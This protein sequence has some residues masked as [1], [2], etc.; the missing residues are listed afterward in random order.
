[1]NLIIAREKI[2]AIEQSLR[3]Y[4][5]THPTKLRI[6]DHMMLIADAMNQYRDKVIPD[7]GDQPDV[8]QDV[9]DALIETL[10]GLQDESNDCETLIPLQQ[11]II[12]TLRGKLKKIWN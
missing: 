9:D 2:E 12:Q 6:Q 8:I 7:H 4:N 3:Y 11:L 10:I 5:E 1:M